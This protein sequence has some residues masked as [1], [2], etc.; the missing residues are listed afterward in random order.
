MR[1][2]TLSA[3]AG[4]TFFAAPLAAQTMSSTTYVMKAGAGDLFER[5][6]SRLVLQSTTNADLKRFAQMMVTDHTNSTADV[7]KAALKAGVRPKPPKLTP[8][9]TRNLVAL[10][11]ARGPDRDTLYI[12]QQKMAHQDALALHQNE[13]ANGR[14]KP[15]QMTAL[16]IVPVVQHHIEMLNA[17]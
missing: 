1:I 13:A 7:K 4:L 5:D 10:R 14:A 15:L 16:K 6:S 2:A 8:A 3:A 9:Q 17:M 11:A 12:S